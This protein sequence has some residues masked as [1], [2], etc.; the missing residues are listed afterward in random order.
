MPRRAAIVKKFIFPWLVGPI[1][2]LCL[3]SL[4]LA[5]HLSGYIPPKYL[6]ENIHP[7]IWTFLG[8][9]LLISLLF[10]AILPRRC[11]LKNIVILSLIL[12]VAIQGVTF[13]FSSFI[14]ALP[15]YQI[16]YGTVMDS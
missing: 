7:F 12:S 8:L 4:I 13:F 3:V 15:N 2:G 10:T 5:G 11:S 16:V 1:M 9:S 14:W 6:P